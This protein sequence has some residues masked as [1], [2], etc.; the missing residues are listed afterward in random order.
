MRRSVEASVE[1]GAPVETVYGYWQ[2]FENLSGSMVEVDSLL[3]KGQTLS[4]WT[5]HGSYG[6]T[7]E[8][9]ALTTRD[10]KGGATGQETPEAPVGP[11]GQV[12][13][14]ELEPDRTRV[15]VTLNYTE[16]GGVEAGVAAIGKWQ[17]PQLMLYRN[18]EALK[19]ILPGSAAAPEELRNGPSTIARSELAAFIAGGVGF[20]IVTGI[21]FTVRR[22]VSKSLVS[23]ANSET[24]ATC[25]PYQPSWMTAEPMD[26]NGH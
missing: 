17:D 5:L 3:T 9:N 21:L 19:A 10:E 20:A 2:T 1:I 22:A 6:A 25:R 15:D 23:E 14:E 18:L 16:P 4:H 13:F 7:V 11:S 24:G 8:F 26:S 12:H